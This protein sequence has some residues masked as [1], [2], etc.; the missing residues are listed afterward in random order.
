[1]IVVSNTSAIMNLAIVKQINL[2]EKLYKKIF[3]PEAVSQEIIFM[4]LDV[5]RVWIEKRVVANRSLIDVLLLE[6]D[7][8]EAEAIALAIEMKG[9][10][11][12]LDERFARKIA[13]RL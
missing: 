6:L 3:I 5:S 12:L 13:S 9:E 10:L 1:M 11:L 2:L 8:G 7:I 4:G